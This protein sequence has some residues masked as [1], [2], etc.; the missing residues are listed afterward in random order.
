ML[1]DDH[2]PKSRA[3]RRHSGIDFRP[4]RPRTVEE[5]SAL[6]DQLRSENLAL[7]REN[8]MFRKLVYR[9]DLTGLYNR[10]HFHERLAQEWSRAQRSGAP[11]SLVVID[12]N[13]F[14]HINDSFGHAAGDQVLAWVGNV[15]AHG[16]RNF[17]VACRIGG[18]E[19][20]IVLPDTDTDGARTVVQ[21]IE[22]TIESA[23]HAPTLP[24]GARIRLSFGVAVSHGRRSATELLQQADVAMYADKRARKAA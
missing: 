21:R 10:R 22:G 2:P 15:L 1:R 11:L 18:D 13:D 12:I 16:C 23:E 5:M 8:S 9:D 24:G 7:R 6:V 20:A 19:F 14:K 3:R 17:D 4:R